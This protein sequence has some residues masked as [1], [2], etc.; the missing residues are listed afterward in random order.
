MKSPTKCSTRSR[1]HEEV[2]SVEKLSTVSKP[3]VTGSIH[4][5]VEH[6]GILP[7]R[8]RTPLIPF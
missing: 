2:A 3:P 5:K 1:R 7:F 6:G 4:T 8:H